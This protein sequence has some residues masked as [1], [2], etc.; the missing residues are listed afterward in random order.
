MAQPVTPVMVVGSWPLQKPTTTGPLT[1]AAPA[2]M[3]PVNGVRMLFHSMRKPTGTVEVGGRSVGA[4]HVGGEEDGTAWG[5]RADGDVRACRGRADQAQAP[6]Q[7]ERAESKNSLEHANR[8]LD[9]L[10]IA[11]L[12]V[13]K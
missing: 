3:W 13:A 1:P 9:R 7:T 5:W 12:S 2:W 10:R 6:R 11:S 8:L 4:F